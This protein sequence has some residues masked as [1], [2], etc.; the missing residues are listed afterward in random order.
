MGRKSYH[1]F[2]NCC[3]VTRRLPTVVAIEIIL[4]YIKVLRN[5]KC[6]SPNISKD[7]MALEKCLSNFDI[8]ILSFDKRNASIVLNTRMNI[9]Q[10]V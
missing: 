3:D 2:S 7:E 6:P 8:V 10:N 9:W 1:F 4:Y 5:A